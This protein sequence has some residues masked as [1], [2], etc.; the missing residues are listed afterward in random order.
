LARSVAR[1]MK[2]WLKLSLVIRFTS[3][4]HSLRVIESLAARHWVIGFASLRNVNN[5]Q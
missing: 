2:I 5:S 4:G 3:L 1:F